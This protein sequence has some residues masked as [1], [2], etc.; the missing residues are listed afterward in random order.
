MFLIVIISVI[1][2]WVCIFFCNQ[3]I[4]NRLENHFIRQKVQRDK[5]LNDVFTHMNKLLSPEEKIQ[6]IENLFIDCAKYTNTA[7]FI[8]QNSIEN[9]ILTAELALHIFAFL[10]VL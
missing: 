3:D 6:K 9:T 8:P 7:A 4:R 2:F 1:L 10:L 5:K